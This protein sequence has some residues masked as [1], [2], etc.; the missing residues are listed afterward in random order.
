[1]S[2][3]HRDSAFSITASNASA[4]SGAGSGAEDHEYPQALVEILVGDKYKIYNQVPHI[5][6]N[7]NVCAAV[8][9][10]CKVQMDMEEIIAFG[11][12]RKFGTVFCKHR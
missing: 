5:C 7:A 8:V 4:F 10:G 6:S 3:K 1:M 11:F 12:A 9:A 2:L